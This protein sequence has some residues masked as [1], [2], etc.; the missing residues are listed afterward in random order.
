MKLIA[1][2]MDGTLLR[3]DKSFDLDRFERAVHALK[4]AGTRVCIAS[5]NSYPKL[6]GYFDDQLRQE[7]L[8]ASTN[9]NAIMVEE[10]GLHYSALDYDTTE[11]IID[12]LNEFSDF[13]CLV[14][15]DRGS[16]AVTQ[17]L[18]ALDHFRLYHPHIDHL[19]NFRDL[20]PEEAILQLSV[21]SK[22]SV[23]D[24]K[25]MTRILNERFPEG[26]AV[27]SGGR[28]IDVFS[29]QGGKGQAIRY[30]QDYLQTDASQTMA[31]GDSLNDQTMMEVVDYSLAM[32]NADPDLLAICRYQ[33]GDNESQAVIDILEALVADPSAAFLAQ[34][35]R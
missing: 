23:A 10:Q 33:I 7:L 28:W 32:G 12:F 25:V 5:G 26:H 31:F 6:R 8:F 35:R 4:E 18:D 2:D 17:D 11:A 13:F 20:N 16:Y 24:N 34:Y 1:I 3:G 29:P 15:T 30:L 14:M 19:A 9:G 21:M 27:T 22:R